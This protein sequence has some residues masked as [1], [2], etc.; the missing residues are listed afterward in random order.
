MCAKPHYNKNYRIFILILI[1]R[2]LHKDDTVC[3]VK[4]KFLVVL[5]CVLISFLFNINVILT[6]IYFSFHFNNNYN[7]N[8]N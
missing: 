6:L 8:F 3:F 2:A 4:N 1:N 7:I 5:I